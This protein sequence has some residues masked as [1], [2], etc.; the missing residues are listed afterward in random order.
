MIITSQVINI[1]YVS[2]WQSQPE[3]PI[4]TEKL[5]IEKI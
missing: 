3:I 5:M 2:A 1:L 4:K